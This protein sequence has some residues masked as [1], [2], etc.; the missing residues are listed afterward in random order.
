[1]ARARL[2][3]WLAL[4]RPGDV[5]MLALAVGLALA[6]FVWLWR[7][8]VA[9]GR[10]RGPEPPAFCIQRGFA[11]FLT[12][13][14]DEEVVRCESEGLASR[15]SALPHAP[16]DLVEL[17]QNLLEIAQ[18]PEPVHKDK[19][20]RL[21]K[22][23]SV[24]ERKQSEIEALLSL[25]A[26][27]AARAERVVD[28]GSGR[29]H[30]TRIAAEVFDR[31]AIGIERVPE[32]VVTAERLGAGTRATFVLL[33][34]TNQA[35]GLQARDLAIGLHACGA[36]GDRLILEASEARC[37]VVLVSCCLQKI[38]PPARQ[39][40]SRAARA[41]GFVLSKE[42]L[43]LSN[44]TARKQGVETTLEETMDARRKRWALTRLLRH[45]GLTV[46]PGEE[47]RGLNRRLAHRPFA[48]LVQ[49]ALTRRDLT[50]AS[51][52]EIEEHDRQGSLEFDKMRRFSLPRAML[53]RALE[54]TVAL[55]R[56][57]SLEECG[58]AASVVEIC[59]LDVTPRNLATIASAH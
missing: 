34:A 14:S 16:R 23:R 5:L 55:D 27:L 6:S 36:L 10:P 59:S 41:A 44:L 4:L 28:V 58:Y 45:R 24:S 17:A 1:M 57:T 22:Q 9:E 31:D 30:F 46:Q 32:R 47:M 50:P 43:G 54:V 11:D 26:P 12:S 3:P 13:L 25:V 8:G 48:D 53:A 19:L 38:P 33:D 35:L 18:L 39:P 15:L 56:A 29:G 21:D 40:S 20:A 49:R 42:S 2:S 52:A 7:D 51:V 37:D